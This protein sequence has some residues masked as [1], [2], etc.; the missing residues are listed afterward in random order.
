MEGGGTDNFNL[1]G[2]T[3]NN[4]KQVT[5]WMHLGKDQYNSVHEIREASESLSLGW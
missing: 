5:I 4:E 1:S 3:V 2:Q